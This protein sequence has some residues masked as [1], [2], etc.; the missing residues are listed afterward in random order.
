M[1]LEEYSIVGNC[2]GIFTQYFRPDVKEE[3]TD[4]LIKTNL[5]DSLKANLN[6]DYNNFNVKLLKENIS[7][8][9]KFV[10]IDD[11]DRCNNTSNT[12]SNNTNNITNINN[13][14]DDSVRIIESKIIKHN[15]NFNCKSYNRVVDKKANLDFF[16]T[17]VHASTRRPNFHL[18]TNSSRKAV[19]QTGDGHFSPVIAFN[20][21][22]DGVLLLD[23]ARFKYFSMWCKI[24]SLWESIIPIDKSTQKPRGFLVSSRYH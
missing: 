12:N 11:I 2:N 22:F 13:S 5:N 15:S 10:S 7:E 16:R 14:N 6:V 1:D 4:E 18:V 17:I 21:K 23:V 20:T 3:Q 24:K 9:S 8:T 19:G